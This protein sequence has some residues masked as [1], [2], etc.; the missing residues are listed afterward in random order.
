M[1]EGL[2]IAASGGIKQ[3]VKMDVLANNMANLNNA[4]FKSD[5]V[6][7]REIFPPFDTNSS[8]ET[9][10]NTLVSPNDSSET[11][12]YVAVDTIYTDHSQGIFQKT[13]NPLDLALEG[14]GFFEVDTPQGIRYTRNGNF[15]LDTEQHVVT[16]DGNFVL[17]SNQKKIKIRDTRGMITVGPD[18]TISVGDGLDNQVAGKIRLVKFEDSKALAKEGN[19]VYKIMDN[20]VEPLLADNLRITQGALE[21]SNVNSVE[22]M[23]NMITAIR[24][25]EAYQKIIQTLDDADDKAVNS[26]GRIV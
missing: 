12:A 9:R 25:F 21:R 14:D 15:R 26:I 13:D 8:V 2:I 23:T 20:E 10:E 6:V 22:E 18:G 19:G 7:F 11:V 5:G 24:A 3:Q 4:G 16:Q 17:N 1:H